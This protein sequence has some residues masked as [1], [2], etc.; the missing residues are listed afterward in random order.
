MAAKCHTKFEKRPEPDGQLLRELR[1]QRQAQPRNSDERRRLPYK[2]WREQRR[3]NKVEHE[4][5]L[6][7][8]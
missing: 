5:Q 8:G 6:Q 2:V 3:L 1:A 4:M 7:M